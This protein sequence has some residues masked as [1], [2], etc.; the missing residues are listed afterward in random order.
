[1]IFARSWQ[2]IMPPKYTPRAPQVGRYWPGKP[3]KDE[4]ELESS[5]DEEEEEQE[6]EQETQ[7]QFEQ[8]VNNTSTTKLVTTMKTTKISEQG[9][10][11]TDEEESSE[12]EFEE[13]EEEGKPVSRTTRI[14]QA[15]RRAAGN[16]VAVDQVD[17]EEEE[18]LRSSGN[19]TNFQSS[20]EETSEEEESDE[21]EALPK[22]PLLRPTFVSKYDPFAIDSSNSA[23]SQRGKAPINGNN[24]GLAN[25]GIG[26]GDAESALAD[27]ARR[28]EEAIQFVENEQ[29][30]ADQAAKEAAMNDSNRGMETVDDTDDID[31]AA[32]RAAWK[33]RELQRIKRDREALIARELEKEELERIRNMDE[34]EREEQDYKRKKEKEEE[35]AQ[36]RGKMQFMQKY[37]HKGGFY[38]DEDIMARDYNVATAEEHTNK[39]VLPKS[40]Q[41]RSGELGRAGRTKWTHLTAEDT[42]NKDSPWFDATNSVNKRSLGK[43]GGM[44]DPN[45]RSKKRRQS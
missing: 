6:Q 41:I 3:L 30:Q 42:S 16:F 22:R 15:S 43:M 28:K 40:L 44:H 2:F 11:V 21:E 19:L 24:I 13:E 20:E 29:R 45:D 27:E 25:Y 7:E 9:P 39:E 31:P 1:V 38:Q 32:E 5:S 23:R 14:R 4:P 37:Y 33:V 34:E 26:S 35:K 10:Y 18:V 36:N 8:K 12:S 17:L